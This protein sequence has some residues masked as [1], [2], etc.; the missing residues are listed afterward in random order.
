MLELRNGFSDNIAVSGSMIDSY[1]NFSG[2]EDAIKFFP[3]A[4]QISFLAPFPSQWFE[5][6]IDTGR[7]GKAISGIEMIFLYLM[8]LGT[9]YAAYKRMSQILP[10]IPVSL[11]SF[12]VI[13][14]IGYAIPNIGAIYRIR[15]DQL[16]PFFIIGS[17]G[18]NLFHVRFIKKY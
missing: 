8:L 2:Y 18:I 14:L 12:A 15:M 9:I 5:A 7:I 6:G 17:Y 3:R 1:L 4:L 11:L 13:I 10:I 16:I